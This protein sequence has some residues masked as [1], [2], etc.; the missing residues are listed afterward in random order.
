[1][2]TDRHIVV[3]QTQTDSY[4]LRFKVSV[5]EEGV[6]TEHTVTVDQMTF[7]RIVGSIGGGCQPLGVVEASFRFL[8]D[9]E[10]KE[11]ILNRFDLTLIP[12]HFPEYFDQIA[13]YM[14]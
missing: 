11:A 7:D 3:R 12:H 9:R 5:E 1:M 14:R 13:A 4:P 6:R 10:P 2:A 8:L